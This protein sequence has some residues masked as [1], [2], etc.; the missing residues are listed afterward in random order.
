MKNT[1]SILR[2]VSKNPP[3][4]T[5]FSWWLVA[6]WLATGGWVAGRWQVAGHH[7]LTTSHQ[8]FNHQVAS[9]QDGSWLGASHCHWW[10]VARGWWLVADSWWLG[11][12]IWNHFKIESE[13]KYSVSLFVCLFVWDQ[14]SDS[15]WREIPYNFICDQFVIKNE[16]HFY[17]KFPI[18]SF[19][20]TDIKGFPLK[21]RWSQMKLICVWVLWTT[22]TSH[23][24]PATNHQASSPRPPPGHH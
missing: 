8:K 3:N 1:F 10:L 2:R 11:F 23:Q 16:I 19:V 20:I 15:F 14:K 5:F 4:E 24:S 6:M 13:K 12:Y 21:L 7:L 22:A 9:H 18:I 17:G